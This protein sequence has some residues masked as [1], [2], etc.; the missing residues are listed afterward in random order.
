MSPLFVV[1]EIP[2]DQ[3]PEYLQKTGRKRIPGTR[4]LFGLMQAKKILLL[5]PLLKFYLDHGLKVTAFYQ[6][7]KYK[8]GKPFAWFPEE[9]A[10]A[11]RQADKD[12][13]NAS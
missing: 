1:Q 12:P 11:R 8:R 10:D 2:D 5:T 3:I 13:D 4:K 6:F 9:V 7:L